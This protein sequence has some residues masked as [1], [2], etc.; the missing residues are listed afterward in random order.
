[1][2]LELETS[3]LVTFAGILVKIIFSALNFAFQKL[4]WWKYPWEGAGVHW[5]NYGN[6]EWEWKWWIRWKWREWKWG[7]RLEWSQW[8][9]KW[10]VRWKWKWWTLQWWIR[11]EHAIKGRMQQKQSSLFSNNCPHTCR[12]QNNTTK[13]LLISKLP[14]S[15]PRTKAAK[16]KNSCQVPVGGKVL[17]PCSY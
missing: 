8:E 16:G 1:M 15:M 14:A 12:K 17:N 13:K 3:N 4:A 7:I 2:L 9:W 11:E 10:R 5:E 6:V